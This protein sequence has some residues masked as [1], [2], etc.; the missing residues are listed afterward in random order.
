MSTHVKL[1]TAVCYFITGQLFVDW[2]KT[3]PHY[4]AIASR[5]KT[6]YLPVSKELTLCD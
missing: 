2:V 5:P 4:L 6:H 3:R 1:R